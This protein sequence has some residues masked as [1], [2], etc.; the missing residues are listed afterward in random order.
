MVRNCPIKPQTTVLRTR[1]SNFAFSK[2]NSSAGVFEITWH[3]RD[4]FLFLL[5]TV[6]PQ[7]YCILLPM[8]GWCCVGKGPFFHRHDG[9]ASPGYLATLDSSQSSPH[10]LTTIF[11]SDWNKI[12]TKYCTG[13]CCTICWYNFTLLYNHDMVILEVIS[14]I[15]PCVQISQIIF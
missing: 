13:R 14:T 10:E 5:R 12:T 8:V 6:L 1:A 9:G 2:H 3:L 11:F 4:A 15:F 7:C